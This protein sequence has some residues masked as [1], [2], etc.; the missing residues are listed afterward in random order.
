MTDSITSSPNTLVAL[1]VCPWVEQDPQLFAETHVDYWQAGLNIELGPF[2]TSN[3]EEDAIWSQGTITFDDGTIAQ[4][5]VE[6]PI[7][8][9]L[10]LA[11]QCPVPFQATELHALEGHQSLWRVV[12]ETEQ[13]GRRAASRLIEVMTTFIAAGAAGVFMPSLATLHSPGLLRQQT[14]GANHPQ[15]ICQL[16]V[17]A[18]HEDDW[19]VTRGLTAFGLPELE[20]PT[21]K[22]LNGAYFCLMDVAANM[23]FQMAPFPPESQ[24]QVGHQMFSLDLGPQGPED[25]ININGTFGT[26]TIKPLT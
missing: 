24:L 2:D 10:E 1:M 8:D 20:T 12:I 14:K 5:I 4:L 3:N 11:D 19:M 23:L 9:I 25:D 6:P 16:C 21:H 17:S 15:T 22:G 26:M 18:W 7:P 13:R